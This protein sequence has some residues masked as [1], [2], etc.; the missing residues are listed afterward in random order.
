VNAVGSPNFPNDYTF[1]ETKKTQPAYISKFFGIGPDGK[2]IASNG[3][4]KKSDSTMK[5]KAYTHPMFNLTDQQKA[6][7]D[8]F[9]NDT[10]ASYNAGK[11]PA[12]TTTTT[13]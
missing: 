10:I 4:Q 11:C 12:T 8:A 3:I 2:P 5:A 7:V 1:N 6:A 9:V 13:K